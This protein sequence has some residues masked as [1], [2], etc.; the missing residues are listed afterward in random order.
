M[1]LYCVRHGESAYNA[2]GRIQ[3]QSDVPLSGLGHRQSRAVAEALS[4]LPV[5]AIYA[6]PLRR[7]M[8]TAQPVA[9]RLHLEIRADP[10]LME[11]H[12]G[13]F[14]EKLRSELDELYHEPYARW[15]SGDPDFAIPGGESRRDLMRR[16]REVFEEIGR[17]DPLRGCPDGQVVVITH[18]GLLAAALKALLEIPAQRHPFVLQNGSISQLELDDGRVRL[19]SLNQVDHLRDVGYG[20]C[21]DL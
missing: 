8:Q 19:L 14:Q 16:G 10:R 12:A 11:I 13:V 6:S 21:G 2:E 3:G 15:K 5:Q 20:G 17:A 18:G 7:A 1:L 9:E 4:G